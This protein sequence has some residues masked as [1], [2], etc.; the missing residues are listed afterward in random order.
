MWEGVRE[1]QGC[2]HIRQSWGRGRLKKLNENRHIYCQGES[3]KCPNLEVCDPTP[4]P[5]KTL[6][7]KAVIS[8][9]TVKFW[10]CV[11]FG[12]HRFNF[13]KILAYELYA[14]LYYALHIIITKI[15]TKLYIYYV[16]IILDYLFCH[17]IPFNI[18]CKER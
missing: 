18:C 7:I 2:S 9:C 4:T 14:I 6:W 1:D 8:H 11:C 15:N 5:S 13:W 10:T 17:K 12:T 3:K 16:S